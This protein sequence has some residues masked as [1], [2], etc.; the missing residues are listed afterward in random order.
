M[1]ISRR[2]IAFIVFCLYL[3]SVAVLCFADPADM[4][5]E[6]FSI[7]GIEADKVAHF[8]MFLPYPVLAYLTFEN[9]DSGKARA[10]ICLATITLTGTAVAIGTEYLQGM[11][12]Y[13]SYDIKDFAAD[14]AGLLSGSLIIL[15]YIL[16]KKT[17]RNEKP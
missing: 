7:F 5:T 9:S 8:L 15:T 1:K 16:L 13:R 4:N 6:S 10:I 14:C 12:E 3:A 11:T 2:H 17:D